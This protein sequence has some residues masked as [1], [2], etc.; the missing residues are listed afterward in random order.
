MSQRQIERKYEAERLLRDGLV[1]EAIDLMRERIL[2]TWE[3]APIRDK[4]GHHELKLMMKY[5]KDFEKNLEN[6]MAEG[7]EAELQ[8]ERERKLFNFKG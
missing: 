7:S 1:R 5:L 6:F 4:E 2:V 3:N 8:I